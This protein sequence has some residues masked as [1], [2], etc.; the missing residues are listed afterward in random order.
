[1]SYETFELYATMLHGRPL[2]VRSRQVSKMKPSLQGFLNLHFNFSFLCIC[3]ISTFLSHLLV[4]NLVFNSV[5][6]WVTKWTPCHFRFWE[7]NAS[8]L[9]PTERAVFCFFFSKNTLP[10]IPNLKSEC[11]YFLVV[12]L[13]SIKSNK[14]TPIQSWV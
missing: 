6:L 8:G 13:M 10:H 4:I 14:T 2:V 3:K 7:F 12:W 5:L 1:M 11:S 9:W